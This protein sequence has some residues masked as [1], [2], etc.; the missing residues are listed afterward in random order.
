MS[1]SV[2]LSMTCARYVSCVVLLRLGARGGCRRCLLAR[3]AVARAVAVGSRRARVCR[4]LCRPM[5]MA[6]SPHWVGGLRDGRLLWGGGG[7][8]RR[9]GMGWRDG[10]L[11]EFASPLVELGE[12]GF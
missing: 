1:R 9:P 5:M 11:Q 6:S 10:S 2:S 12:G 4:G 7:A 8:S 3:L